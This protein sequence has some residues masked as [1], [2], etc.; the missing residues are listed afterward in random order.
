MANPSPLNNQTGTQPSY[1]QQT[2]PASGSWPD[3]G[4][5]PQCVAAFDSFYGFV[6][7]LATTTVANQTKPTGVVVS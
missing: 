4:Y 2:A 7:P 3:G 1:E 6:G 5:R